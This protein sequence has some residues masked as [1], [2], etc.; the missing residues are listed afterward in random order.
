MSGT[1]RIAAGSILV[2]LVVL[3]IKF[4][5]YAVTGSVALYSDAL[6]SFVNV[7][8]AIA[9]L[10]A[11][12]L[13]EQPPDHNHPYGHHKVEYFSAVLAGALIAVAALLI[14]REAWGAVRAPRVIE[15]PGLGLALAGVATVV[16]AAW[17]A[18]LVT[19]GR[20]LRSPAL[21]ADGRHLFSDVVTSVG[22][23]AGIGLALYTGWTILDPA[24]A[25]LVALNI[26]WSGWEVIRESLGGLMDEAVTDAELERIRAVISR[27][28][29]G[30]IEAHD[31][32][33]RNAGR[34][35]FIDFH[36]VVPAQMSVRDAH[37]ICDR[38]ERALKAAVEGALITIHVEP[39]NKAKLSGI[40]VL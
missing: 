1:V 27:H 30:A 15:A 13:S 32:R 34:V 39:E 26:L 8:T 16:N 10:L 14:L 20:R 35:T 19:C 29:E 11:V 25:A 6:E 17:S 40:V 9:A 28:A 5:A 38:I 31:V 36:L 4:L 21:V 2:G 18:V 37:D 33:T 3:G 12:R 24:L 22:V 23:V 7:A